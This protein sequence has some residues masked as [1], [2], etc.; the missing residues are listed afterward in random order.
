MSIICPCGCGNTL[1]YGRICIVGA[2]KEKE[3]IENVAEAIF[4]TQFPN[5][6][7]VKSID[8]IKN[9]FRKQAE[10]AIKICKERE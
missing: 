2:K 5:G 8:M 9:N 6:S 3:L 10:A 4:M 1:L 7:F